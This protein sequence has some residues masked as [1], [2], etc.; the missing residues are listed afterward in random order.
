M[1]SR[2]RRGSRELRSTL[3]RVLIHDVKNIGFRLQMLLSNLEEH[4]GDPDFKRSVQDLLAATVGRLEDIA[5]RHQAHEDA[6]LVKIALDLNDVLQAV[7]STATTGR[8]RLKASAAQKLPKLALA[9]GSPPVVWGDPDYLKDAFTSLLDN[10]LEAAGPGGKVVVR[11]FASRS[12]AGQRAAV[13]IIDNGTGMSAEA[14]RDRLR[15]P[16][17]TTKTN[18]IGLG[19]F[20][21]GRIVRHH[22]GR[23]QIL[24]QPGGGTVVRLSFP[25]AAPA[26]S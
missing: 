15:H 16:F 12:R 24:S 23:I 5:A 4:Y 21:A 11:S 13:D 10:A 26:A 22:R 20:T 9:L 18:G 6:V 17:Q 2:P 8:S 14:A 7:A 25:G 1:A 19:L 3:D